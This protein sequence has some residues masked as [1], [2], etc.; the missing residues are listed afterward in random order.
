MPLSAT[1]QFFAF[2]SREAFGFF[3]PSLKPRYSSLMAMA[4]TAAT[5]MRSL[6]T[7]LALTSKHGPWPLKS[8]TC[9]CT[10]FWKSSSL[11]KSKGGF[12][13]DPSICHFIPFT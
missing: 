4:M 10:S 12:V 11:T 5:A 8:T 7:S 3:R 9:T 2:S 13:N 1:S 6:A